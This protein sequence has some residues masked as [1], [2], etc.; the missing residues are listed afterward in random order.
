ML[1]K[2]VTQEPHRC[3]SHAHGLEARLDPDRTDVPVGFIQVVHGQDRSKVK[4]TISV[5][6]S[7]RGSFQ[8]PDFRR[9]H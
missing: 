9:Q 1:I 7:G 3:S 6:C 5:V 8:S 4:K 2:L